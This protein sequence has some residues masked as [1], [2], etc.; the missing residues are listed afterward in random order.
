MVWPPDSRHLIKEACSF[1]ACMQQLMETES[2]LLWFNVSIAFYRP[3]ASTIH[4]WV[5][6]VTSVRTYLSV[7]PVY[8]ALFRP[9]LSYSLRGKRGQLHLL[10]NTYHSILITNLR[11]SLRRFYVQTGVKAWRASASQSSCHLLSRAQ[12]QV[13][14]YLGKLSVCSN[15]SRSVFRTLAS[16]VDDH[17]IYSVSLSWLPD[18]YSLIHCLIIYGAYITLSA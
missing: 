13:E 14:F 15:S 2:P 3:T 8:N 16:A 12:W 4:A 1:V 10:V 9:C 7:T 18:S 17:S 6:F 11:S 5:L